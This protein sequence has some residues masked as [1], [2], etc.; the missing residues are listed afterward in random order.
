MTPI[1][2]VRAPAKI[3]LFLGCGERREDGFHELTTVYQAVSL[4]DELVARPGS[5]DVT[6]EVR[7][8]GARAVPDD[9]D[10][11]AVR[12]ARLLAARAGVPADVHLQLDKGIP[13][14]GGLAGGSADAAAALV[15][16]DAL[17]GTGVSRA[18]LL[19]L[20]AELGSDVPFSLHGGTALGTGRGEQ[21]TE[22]LGHGQYHWVLALAEGG[23]ATPTVYAELD[24]MRAV[25]GLHPW[26]SLDRVLAAL[27]AGDA[28]ALGT[29]LSN[30]LQPAAL[31]LRPD[32][33][34]ALEA[35]RELGAVGAVVSGSGPTVAFL[36]K[37][38]A[39]AI[40]VAAALAGMGVCRSVRRAHGPVHG[41]RLR[42]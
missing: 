17:W 28:V 9:D 22:V 39:Q 24:R 15:A 29:A 37:T 1:A 25:G 12:A 31:R 16:C 4:Y 36:V 6:V 18:D 11:L 2:I 19:E 32:L 34:R 42:D 14:A 38:G 26:G 23:L 41:A 35:G 30:D 40:D 27:R 7:G 20:A 21:L 3:N 10:N 8:E 5:G 33:R 13:V